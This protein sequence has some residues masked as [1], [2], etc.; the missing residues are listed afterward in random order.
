M[1]SLQDELRV[2]A[3]V[4]FIRILVKRWCER[5]KEVKWAEAVVAAGLTAPSIARIV[6]GEVKYPQPA[7]LE[8]LAEEIAAKAQDVLAA[9]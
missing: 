7:T 6:S 4:Y 5:N 2:G 8:K 9:L 3:L 1:K